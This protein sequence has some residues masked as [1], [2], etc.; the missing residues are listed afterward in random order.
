[1]VEWKKTKI[2]GNGHSREWDVVDFVVHDR[3]E[4]RG[5]SYEIF[6]RSACKYFI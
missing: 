5:V 4:K 3:V 1:M 6:G 2:V